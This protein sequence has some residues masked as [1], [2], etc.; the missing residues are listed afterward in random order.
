MSILAISRMLRRRWTAGRFF[1]NQSGVAALEFAL[2]LPLM[3]VLYLGGF[4][5]SEA[6]TINR[7]VTHATSVLGDLVAQS[8]SISDGEMAN[9]LDAVEAVMSPYPTDEL[10]IIISGVQIDNRGNAKVSWSDARFAT[11]YPE[12]T[13]YTLPSGLGQPNTFLVAAEVRYLYT[14][15]F[16]HALTGSFNLHDEFYLRP[17]LQNA[18]ERR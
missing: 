2:I 11:P 5:V 14:P 18:V 12:G 3:V 17:R 13:S 6:F 7:K 4:E 16:G 9:I 8:E 15:L 10:E 1:L